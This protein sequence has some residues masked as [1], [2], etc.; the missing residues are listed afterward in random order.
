MNPLSVGLQEISLHRSYALDVDHAAVDEGKL[1][2][3]QIA[4]GFGDLDLTGGFLH[5]P[6]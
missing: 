3:Q 4:G 6:Q 5:I 1:A 2:V